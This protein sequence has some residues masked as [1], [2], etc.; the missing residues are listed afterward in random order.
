MTPELIK[1]CREYEQKFSRVPDSWSHYKQYALPNTFR[2][3]LETVWSFGV[4]KEIRF[5]E[6]IKN[7][8]KVIKLK[9]DFSAAY[10]NIFFT[11]QYKK[12]QWI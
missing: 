11:L 8:E 2:D 9:P 12:S 10:N 6:A 1:L 3:S 5:E 7:F 4:S